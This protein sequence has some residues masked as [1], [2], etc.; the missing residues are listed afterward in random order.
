MNYVFLLFFIATLRSAPYVP[1][2]Q[3][4]AE[5]D[6][7]KD[8]MA[9]GFVFV[10][11]SGLFAAVSNMIS[12]GAKNHAKNKEEEERLNKIEEKYMGLA[13]YLTISANKIF[14]ESIEHTMNCVK[15][16]IKMYSEEGTKNYAA[17][18]NYVAGSNIEGDLRI[19]EGLLEKKQEKDG[20]KK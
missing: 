3:Y 17:S 6:I 12:N 16:V 19:C 8:P 13:S 1:L 10:R 5:N 2:E 11:C 7:Y 18:G 9:L 20:K 4:C 14:R 15:Q